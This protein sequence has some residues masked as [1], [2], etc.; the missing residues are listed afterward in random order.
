MNDQYIE[1]TFLYLIALSLLIHFLVY[2]L[3]DFLPVNKSEI[4]P[5]SYIVE[6][7]DLPNLNDSK[8]PA[9][10]AAKRK[11][12][13]RIRVNRETAPKGEMPVEHK[14][15]KISKMGPTTP[16]PSQKNHMESSALQEPNR[17]PLTKVPRGSDLLV[18]R[19][20]NL[21]SLAK[22]Y[23][24]ANKLS[25]IEENYRKKYE[26]EVEDGE[27]KFLNTDDIQFGS[28]LRRFETA[29]YGVWRYPSDAVRL[30]IEGITPVKITFNRN[31]E[32]EKV[33][34]LESSGSKLLDDEV[35]RTLRL[36]GPLGG[37]PKGYGKDKFS[38]VAFFQYGIIRGVSRGM[39]H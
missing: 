25:N 38:L 23:P 30:G 29:V 20:K 19:K 9:D 26:S 12:D 16:L 4:K 6:L 22:L 24:S 2:K 37:F 27:T 31:G 28:F 11:S 5:E 33:Q 34:L 18:E 13:K 3:F 39:L 36:I 17:E 10:K 15:P 32:I 8:A 21:P 1:K 14:S 35:F 7:E